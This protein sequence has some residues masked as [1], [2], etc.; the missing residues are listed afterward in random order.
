[1]KAKEYAEKYND[2]PTNETLAEI[3]NSFVNE[4]GELIESRHAR[5]NS[6]CIAI[7]KEQ[8]QKW[9]AFSNLVPGIRRNGFRLLIEEFFPAM[10]EP[11]GWGNLTTGAVDAGDTQC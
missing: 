1:M 2:A 7:L 9:V 10:I 4:I 8:D 11:L 5:S 6:A 3:C